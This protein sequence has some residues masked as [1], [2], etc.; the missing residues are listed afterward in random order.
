MELHII[1]GADASGK[2]VFMDSLIKDAPYR[3]FDIYKLNEI[4][5][6]YYQDILNCIKMDTLSKSSS[7]ILEITLLTKEFEE[8]I[9]NAIEMNYKIITYCLITENAKINENRNKKNIAPN[10]IRENYRKSIKNI[11]RLYEITD[12]LIIYNSIKNNFEL[13]CYRE[14]KGDDLLIYEK[15]M[16]YKF[17]YKNILLPI[18]YIKFN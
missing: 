11:P 6:E 16:S 15:Y 1:I 5:N 13:I 14:K 8:L 2:T 17:I 12:T 3:N 4:E 10:R 7:L 18:K 9:L